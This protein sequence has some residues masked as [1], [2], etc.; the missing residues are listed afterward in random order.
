MELVPYQAKRGKKYP[1]GTTS[2]IA[3]LSELSA[4]L[5]QL[6]EGN[7]RFVPDTATRVLGKQVF[8]TTLTQTD[9]IAIFAPVLSEKQGDR[10]PLFLLE[11]PVLLLS[12]LS[13][14][15]KLRRPYK[16]LPKPYQKRIKTTY[17]SKH[18]RDGLATF[19]DSKKKARRYMRIF[20]KRLGLYTKRKPP[21]RD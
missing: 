18:T 7:A 9:A 17:T 14:Q 19:L 11:L 21:F 3:L 16:L 4:L 1:S 20:H 15:Q 5:S 13:S 12:S 8:P 2:E 6:P 10:I